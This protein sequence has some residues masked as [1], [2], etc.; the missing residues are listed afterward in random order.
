VAGGLNFEAAGSHQVTVQVSD[1]AGGTSSQTFTI[2][3]TNVNEAPEAL[4]LSS[5]TIAENSAVGAIVGTLSASD[6]EGNPLSFTL[7]DTA[8]GRFAISGNQLVVAGGLNFEA[9]ASHQV[10]VQVSD[11]AG[12]TTS[13]TF[14][15]AVSDV[16]ELPTGLA[17]TGNSVDENSAAGTVIGSL[18]ANDPD[19]DSLSFTLTDDAGGRFA[20]S[21]NQLV[22]AGALDFET[23]TSHQVTIEVDDGAGGTQTRT[24]T[25]NIRN[26]QD[27]SPGNDTLTGTVG[28]DTLGGLGGDDV[29][30]GLAGNDVLRGGAGRDLLNGGT[31]NDRLLGNGGNDT[32]RGAGGNDT[33]D[34][35][36]ANDTLDGGGGADRLIGGGGLDVLNGGLGNDDM[37][38]NDGND[39]LNGQGG[40]DQL[41]GAGGAD[42]LRGAAGNDVLNGGFGNDTMSG[43]AGVDRFVFSGA[44]GRDVISDFRT[45]ADIIDLSGRGLSFNALDTRQA[46]GGLDTLIVIGNNRILLE[47]FEE[48]DLRGNMFDFI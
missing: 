5:S 34:G 46:N 13:Q 1:G 12:G 3:V 26:L 30:N 48:N 15:I 2:T 37:R 7:T 4:S 16:N 6:P 43:G 47:G 29:L 11:G 28:P 39:T 14:V 21:G 20:I 19:G 10:T 33:L 32:L 24:F 31:G 23:A 9:A 22:V 18:A 27:P 38:G 35:G 36:A 17:L 45:G 41:Q 25:V 42:V 40:N 44:F 8:G